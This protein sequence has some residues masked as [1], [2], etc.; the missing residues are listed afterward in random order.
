M[1][2]HDQNHSHAHHHTAN[3]RVLFWSF[4]AIFTFMIV[5]AVGGFLANRVALMSDDGHMLSDDAA[6]RLIMLAF[7]IGERKATKDKTYVF[8]RFEIIAVFI[9]VV[10]LI[11]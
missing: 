8:R 1:G 4:L 3:I 11:V 10:T 9:N 7:K 5:D 6:L 2:H